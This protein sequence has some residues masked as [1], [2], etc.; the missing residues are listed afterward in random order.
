MSVYLYPPGTGFPCFPQGTWFSFRCLLRPKGLQWKYSNPLPHGSITWS[1]RSRIR[2]RVTLRLTVSQSV[3]QYVL[4]SS[5]LC[6]RLTRYCFLFKSLGLEFILS[7][8]GALSDERPSLSFVSHSQVICLC[9]H[10]LLT[11]L[12]FT[13]LHTFTGSIQQIMLY[14]SLVAHDTLCLQLQ[15]CCSWVW[16]PQLGI[17]HYAS[18]LQVSQILHIPQTTK[19]RADTKE[20]AQKERKTGMRGHFVA[21]ARQALS[22]LDN[23]RHT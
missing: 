1:R 9:A 15:F 2:V 11:F 10:L 18:H 5:P 23:A 17:L 13:H 4:V 6:G 3:S 22:Y 21:W 8:W 16:F 19:I 14:Y 20:G 12:P 7:L